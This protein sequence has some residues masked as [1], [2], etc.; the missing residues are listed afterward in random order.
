MPFF[1]YQFEK[2]KKKKENPLWKQTS[3]ASQLN[4]ACQCYCI[5]QG[6]LEKL[7]QGLLPF[8]SVIVNW[9][10][11]PLQE[12]SLYVMLLERCQEKGFLFFVGFF[13][14]KEKKSPIFSLILLVFNK[15]LNRI[16]LNYFF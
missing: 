9:S 3:L 13:F 4:A 2:K 5:V 15:S 11:G 8:I 12:G 10:Y 7:P 1:L 14:E 16:R 6:D